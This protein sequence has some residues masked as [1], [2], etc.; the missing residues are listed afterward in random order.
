MQSLMY[1]LWQEPT[2]VA[3]IISP[4]QSLTNMLSLS[5]KPH[6]RVSVILRIWCRSMRSGFRPWGIGIATTPWRQSLQSCAGRCQRRT[7]E[8]CSNLLRALYTE[9][10]AAAA[11]AARQ[12][13]SQSRR[14]GSPCTADEQRVTPLLKHSAAQL[15]RTSAESVG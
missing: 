9:F 5:G 8:K 11:A 2:S 14:Q 6:V 4:P 7:T 1:K 15:V 13:A 10:D 3:G 12:P